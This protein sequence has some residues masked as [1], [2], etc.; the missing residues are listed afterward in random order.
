[1]P[2]SAQIPAA[3]PLTHSLSAGCSPD[4]GTTVRISTAAPAATS[5]VVRT[6]GTIDAGPDRIEAAI[7]SRI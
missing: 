5:K 1:M 2:A 3:T 7:A 4:A 6:R